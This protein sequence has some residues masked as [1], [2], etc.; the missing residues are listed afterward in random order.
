MNDPVS[1]DAYSDL[2]TGIEE[3][4]SGG[5]RAPWT[6]FRPSTAPPD[7]GEPP[8]GLDAPVWSDRRGWMEETDR[9]GGV[10]FVWTDPSDF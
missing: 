8:A 6:V 3:K 2:V 9:S 5:E 10:P 1:P 4:V 7:A